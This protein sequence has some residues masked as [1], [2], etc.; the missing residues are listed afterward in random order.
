MS[1]LTGDV[2]IDAADAD[3]KK[4]NHN[5]VVARVLYETTVMPD[6][7]PI[8]DPVSR[9]ADSHLIWTHNGQIHDLHAPCFVR[10]HRPSEDEQES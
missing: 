6:P 8:R 5:S 2:L 1:R 3:R 7:L 4:H 10:L 9:A